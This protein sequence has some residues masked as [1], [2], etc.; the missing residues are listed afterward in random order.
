MVRIKTTN[1][2][3]EITLS[4][5]TYFDAEQFSR[6]Y[7]WLNLLC[8]QIYTIYILITTERQFVPGE[9]N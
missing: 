2:K 3:S 7:I 8:K 1:W 6:E 9:Q 5:E 4:N